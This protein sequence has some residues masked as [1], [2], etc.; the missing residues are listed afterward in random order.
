MQCCVPPTTLYK[1]I[2][3][4]DKNF[5]L[6]A[7]V[8]AVFCQ[9]NNVL[10]I[11]NLSSR[12][13]KNYTIFIEHLT[14]QSKEED[15]TKS[16]KDKKYFYTYDNLS[17]RYV[18]NSKFG[19]IGKTIKHIVLPSDQLSYTIEQNLSDICKTYGIVGQTKGEVSYINTSVSNRTKYYIDNNG[20]ETSKVFAISNLSKKISDI[21]RL[22]FSIERNLAIE[23]LI[24]IGHCVKLQTKTQE[25][26]D[27]SGK[28]ILFSSYIN[29]NKQ[30]EWQTTAKLELIRTNKTI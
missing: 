9:Y 8:P 5:G 19:V 20:F 21:S 15:I 24:K 11:M 23:N 29:W 26:I 28:Y 22:S 12:I 17:T 1:T 6:Y 2:K 14:H 3:E 4:L 18:G 13:K 25:H 10:Q 7:G 27:I 30:A 16:M